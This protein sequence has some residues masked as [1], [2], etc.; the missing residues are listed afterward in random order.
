[1]AADGIKLIAD[2]SIVDHLLYNPTA[3]VWNMDG[4]R[5]VPDRMLGDELIKRVGHIGDALKVK[6]TPKNGLEIRGSLHKYFTGADNTSPFLFSEQREAVDMLASDLQVEPEMLRLYKLEWAANVE[7]PDDAQQLRARAIGCHSAGFKAFNDMTD[8][9]AANGRFVSRKHYGIKMYT[10]RAD[11]SAFRYEYVTENYK[12]NSAM[13]LTA[14]TLADLKNREACVRLTTAALGAYQ[15][16]LFREQLDE[17]TPERA[18]LWYAERSNAAYWCT[19]FAKT[20][21]ERKRRYRELN[22]FADIS[23]KHQADQSTQI[24]FSRIAESYTYQGNR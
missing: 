20:G 6:Y 5:S 1:M 19:D 2:R 4:V 7:P 21:S 15:K 18:R 16:I 12:V 9:A 24:L 3:I 13:G 22:K 10:P 11:A 17:A 14:A 23:K 8:E